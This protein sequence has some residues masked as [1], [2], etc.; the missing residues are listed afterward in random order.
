MQWPVKGR[1]LHRYG[2]KR[3]E[4]KVP[5]NGVFIN[6]NSGTAV[7]APHHGR[8]VFSDWMKS[9]G[10]LLIIDHGGGYMT[11]YAHNQE[12]LKT[13]GDWVL[14]GENIALVGDSGGQPRSGLYF[15]IRYKG[16]P[17]NPQ[18]WLRG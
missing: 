7:K 10:Q 6:A 12:L 5:W 17:S 16:R 11:L 13:V 2:E 9:F 1:V 14:P 15:E 18:V 8:V 3:T 4:S